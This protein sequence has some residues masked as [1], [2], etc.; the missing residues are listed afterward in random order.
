MYDHNNISVLIDVFISSQ[1]ILLDVGADFNFSSAGSARLYV[2]WSLTVLPWRRALFLL[3][4][5]GGD[6]DHCGKGR[7]CACVFTYRVAG[8]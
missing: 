7:E 1:F 2:A 8:K 4:E 3:G 5:C 6:G